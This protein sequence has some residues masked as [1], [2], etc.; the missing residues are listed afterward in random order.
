MA[1]EGW[2]W[3]VPY[4][5]G[6]DYGTGFVGPERSVGVLFGWC[7]PTSQGRRGEKTPKIC[8]SRAV[9]QVACGGYY[10]PHTG[11][12]KQGLQ[13]QV[14]HV[15]ASQVRGSA[16]PVDFTLMFRYWCGRHQYTLPYC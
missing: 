15:L 9:A 12:T 8:I 13:Q 14:G 6:L 3:G 11:E 7:R 10:S 2:V 1:A 16:V 5:A 4:G